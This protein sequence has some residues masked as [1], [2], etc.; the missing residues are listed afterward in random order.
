M[1]IVKGNNRPYFL[2][3]CIFGISFLFQSRNIFLEPYNAYEIRQWET[4]AVIRDYAVNNTPFLS[5]RASQIYSPEHKPEERYFLLDFPLYSYTSALVAR[6]TGVSFFPAR[7][8]NSIAT[9]ATTVVLFSIAVFLTHKKSIAILAAIIFN[10]AAATAFLSVAVQPD[11]FMLLF[12]TAAWYTL[13]RRSKNDLWYGLMFTT[14]AVLLKTYTLLILVPTISYQ[15]WTTK[16][17]RYLWYFIIP[18][19]A[20]SGWILQ[21]LGTDSFTWWWIPAPQSIWWDRQAYSTSFLAGIR[22]TNAIAYIR[23]TVQ[24]LFSGGILTAPQFILMCIGIITLRKKHGAASRQLLLYF[25]GSVC[26]FFA[27]LRGNNLHVYYPLPLAPMAAIATAYGLIVTVDLLRH[28][29]FSDSLQKQ[30]RGICLG[31]LMLVGLY[32]HVAYTHVRTVTLLRQHEIYRFAANW[33][34]SQ[35]I[36]PPGA[37]I[38]LFHEE[39]SPVFLAM[40]NRVGWPLKY[41]NITCPDHEATLR[42]L[43]PDYIIIYALTHNAPEDMNWIDDQTLIS[44]LQHITGSQPLFSK[45]RITVF[46]YPRKE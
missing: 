31:I 11:M 25:I 15:L 20:Y 9:A 34:K 44:C 29:L 39:A 19:L 26:F 32:I 13:L 38:A 8:V 10:T 14:I 36:V 24:R 2:A 1:K 37:T 12:L 35:T 22:H 16:D 42:Q 40:M 4:Y 7:L 27:V 43:Q 46:R 45:Q 6:I 3:L 30:Y 23:E 21:K 41:Q 18:P 33:T 5:P 17:K 28:L